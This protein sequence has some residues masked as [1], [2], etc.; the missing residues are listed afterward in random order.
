MKGK[1]ARSLPKAFKVTASQ[2]HG[3][4][5]AALGK[6]RD[7]RIEELIASRR[8][9][10]RDLVTAMIT[11]RILDPRAEPATAQALSPESRA[12]SLGD[13]LGLGKTDAA[14]LYAAMDWLPAR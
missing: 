3:H 1:S 4:V 2:P 9:R 10:N 14:E 11:A 6:L 5:A 12:G 13:M 7:L 8:S